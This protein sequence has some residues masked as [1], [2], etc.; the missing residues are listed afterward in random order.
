MKAIRTPALSTAASA[1]AMIL[2]GPVTARCGQVYWELNS[3][4]PN[5]QSNGQTLPAAARFQLGVF[6][7]GFVPTSTN[8]SEWAAHWRSRD[9]LPY[10]PLTGAF[11]RELR[12]DEITVPFTEGARLYC[13]GYFASSVSS[14]EYFLATDSSWLVPDTD[15]RAF[16]VFVDLEVAGEVI[17]GAAFPDS[18]TIQTAAVPTAVAPP[19]LFADWR[20]SQFSAQEAKDDAISGP[21]ADPDHDGRVNLLEYLTGTSPL[22]AGQP[23]VLDLGAGTGSAAEMLSISF[24]S[25]PSARTHFEFQSSRDLM[26]WISAGTLAPVYDPVVERWSIAPSISPTV[27][28]SFWRLRAVSPVEP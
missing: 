6:T 10:D 23:L 19:F 14:A 28:R 17:L 25:P 18:G 8:L 16:P 15:P 5:L 22:T 12:F 3:Q 4:A 1:M 20:G 7:G 9:E 11:S 21:E 2:S 13:W 24:P 26:E 27:S